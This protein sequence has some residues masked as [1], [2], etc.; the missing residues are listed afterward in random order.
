MVYFKVMFLS[1]VF[2]TTIFNALILLPKK[3]ILVTWRLQTIFNATFV[4]ATCCT[5]L[6]RLEIPK[7]TLL[8]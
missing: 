3:S 8:Q 6:N 5:T 7:A 4:A 2:L 1:G